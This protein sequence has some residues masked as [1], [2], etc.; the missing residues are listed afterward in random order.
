M[1]HMTAPLLRGETK[2]EHERAKH[3]I[4]VLAGPNPNEC[5][6]RLC[7]LI[8]IVMDSQTKSVHAETAAGLYGDFCEILT[9]KSSC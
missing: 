6:S 5:L 4:R 3:Q 9:T 2:L 7:R 8:T 1:Q